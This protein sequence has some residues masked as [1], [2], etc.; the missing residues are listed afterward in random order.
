MDTMSAEDSLARAQTTIQRIIAS[1]DDRV[2]LVT[3]IA[4]EIGAEIIEDV[5]PPGHDLNSVD[6][7]RRYK[8]S[9]TPIREALMLLEKEGLVDIPPRRRPRVLVMDLPMIRE[10]Y[11]T[12]AAILEFVSADV[13]ETASPEELDQLEAAVAD[14]ARA[15]SDGN[16]NAYLWANIAFHDLNLVV[17][18][19]LTAKRIV[20]SLLL[21]TI[22][23][24]RKSLSQEGRLAAS[25]DDHKRLVR[26]YRERDPRLAAALV[27]ANHYNALR[28]LESS[29]Q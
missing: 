25:L 18:K 1:R 5:I 15:C 2:S 14:M 17:S 28:N 10:I 27:H 22:R 19:N 8:T 16:V 26:A 24:R 20:E 9:R 23:L 3:Q 11:R 4:I 6:L 21:K 13:A 7:S 12:R 29:S